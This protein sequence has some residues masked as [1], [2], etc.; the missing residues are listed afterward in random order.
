MNE[1]AAQVVE[2]WILARLRHTPLADVAAA[3]AAVAAS[4]SML[5]ATRFDIRRE[6]HERGGDV[7]VHG[8]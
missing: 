1:S 4:T 8:G 5:D 6:M 3:D 7:L 2:R